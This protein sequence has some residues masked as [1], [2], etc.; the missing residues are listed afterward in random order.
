[1][2]Y[3]GDE[4]HEERGVGVE[5]PV[6]L[7]LVDDH[8]IVRSGLRML[9]LSESGMQIVG[10]AG[11][12]EE[13]IEAVRRLQPD[14][15]I[16]DVSMPGMN[17][18]EATRRIKAAHPQ[19]AVLALTMYED[20]Q[21]FFEMLNAG[22]SGYIPKRAAP[23][24]LV[25]AIKVVAEGN[26]FLYST[27]ARFLIRDMAERAGD[28]PEEGDDVLTA[29]EREVLTCIAEGMTNREIAEALV[30]S[31]KTVERHRENIMAKLDMHNRV[32]LVKY[33]IKKG[34]ITEQ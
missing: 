5:G 20:E 17:G 25:S 24:D 16:M 28:E 12:G 1:V 21:Y 34:L 26:V 2:T 23:D 8:P 30:I 6:K 19:T 15:V 27:L 3:A 14:V 32:E 7:L 33:A 13:A 29:R 9:F 11:S 18:I 4:F 31:I 10:E 22:A